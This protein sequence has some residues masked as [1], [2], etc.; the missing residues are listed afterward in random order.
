MKQ[1]KK[2]LKQRAVFLLLSRQKPIDTL[3]KSGIR[4]YIL[5]FDG[6]EAGRKGANRFK[7]HIGND[8]FITDVLLPMGKD[9]NDLSEEELK[10][11]LPEFYASTNRAI[12]EV[13]TPRTQ[14]DIILRNYF[15][16]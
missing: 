5:C 16:A 15:K 13:V 14:N 4:S 10:T 6:D 8:V 7:K 12:M 9:V 1:L 3:K 11:L 2:Q